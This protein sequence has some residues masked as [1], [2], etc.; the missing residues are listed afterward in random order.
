MLSNGT[1]W[2]EIGT[3]DMHYEN[4]S[5]RFQ[6]IRTNLIDEVDVQA[7]KAPV[8]SKA[9]NE[10][11]ALHNE[12]NQR[13]MPI[14]KSE[15]FF[16]ALQVPF[17]VSI[18]KKISKGY[19]IGKGKDKLTFIPVNGNS[20]IGSVYSN[21]QVNYAEVWTDTDVELLVTKS[22]IKENIVLRTPQSPTLFSFE[23]RGAVDEQLQAGEL[24]ILPAWLEDS[25]GITGMSVKR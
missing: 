14:D 25:N 2:A 18:P 4:T 10:I 23:V 24:Q 5:G 11:K 22:G 21:N 17:D 20:V 3:T 8:S 15:T 16:K 1:Y 19:S 13:R 12:Q 9:V 6:E 7:F